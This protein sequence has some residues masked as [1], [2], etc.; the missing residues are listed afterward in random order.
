MVQIQLT[1]RFQL[2]VSLIPPDV[3]WYRISLDLGKVA[4]LLVDL[5]LLHTVAFV[6][7]TEGAWAVINVNLKHRGLGRILILRYLP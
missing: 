3:K 7:S 2:A 5:V 4:P 1:A 6:L